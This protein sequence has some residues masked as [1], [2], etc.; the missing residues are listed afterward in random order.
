[1]AYE[2]SIAD[3]SRRVDFHTA[4]AF[5]TPPS[6][7]QIRLDPD[8]PPLPD[9]LLEEAACTSPTS[10]LQLSLA[11]IDCFNIFYRLHRLAL[12]A[13]SHWIEKVD[14]LTLSN[15]LYETE[16]IILSVPDYSRNFL[17]FG[18]SSSNEQDD[19]RQRAAH[20]ASVIEALLAA[21]QIF[22]YAALRDIPN[23]A[24]ISTILLER[25]RVAVARPIVCTIHVWKKERNFNMLL[26]T[27]VVACS[28]APH[29]AGREWWIR[30]LVDIMIEMNIKN[31]FDLEIALQSVAWVDT[32]FNSVLGGIW[33]EVAQH[34]GARIMGHRSTMVDQPLSRPV[35]PGLFDARIWESQLGDVTGEHGSAESVGYEKGRWE[36]DGWCI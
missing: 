9:K 28:V 22:V 27:F 8:A 25:L 14:R 7:P 23:N 3:S 26:W 11:G 31:R 32:Y 33:E 15:L 4:A 34:R 12:A 24:K 16:Y 17:D 35:D 13:S 29:G 10:L 36:V 21:A 2:L 19:D 18:S 30:Q 20:T 1:M 5:H 6:F